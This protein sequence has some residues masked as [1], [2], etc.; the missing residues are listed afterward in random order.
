MASGARSRLRLTTSQR[1]WL[2]AAGVA[3][4]AAP[5]FAVVV[6]PLPRPA[7][8]PAIPWP[9]RVLAFAVSEAH[10]VHVHLE[11]DSHS[12][13][14]SDRVRAAGMCL[15]APAHLVTAPV[16]GTGLSLVMHRRQRGMK[17]AFNVAQF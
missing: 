2:L 5:L 14:L 9:A 4:V 12:F 16:L 13:S 17:L 6:T 1:I 7:A 8:G 10:V 3:A 15:A 11:G